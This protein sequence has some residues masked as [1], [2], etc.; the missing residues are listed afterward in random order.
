MANHYLAAAG[1]RCYTING[2][3][4][5]TKVSERMRHERVVTLHALET[6]RMV[7]L[8]C[9]TW[10]QTVKGVAMSSMEAFEHSV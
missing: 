3:S 9:S 6:T 7:G 1:E 5:Y 2:Y 10:D 8:H 4:V